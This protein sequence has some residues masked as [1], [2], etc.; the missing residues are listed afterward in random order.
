MT[1]SRS[2]AYI[3]GNPRF[4]LT[5]DS[6]P[7]LQKGQMTMVYKALAPYPDVRSLEELSKRCSAQKYE[8]SYKRAI[9]PGN[10]W[11]FLRMSILYHL[12]RMRE[13]GIIRE[14]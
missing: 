13:R 2:R 5:G 1:I 11:L 8:E 3:D 4:T 9:A 10:A 6:V 12:R 7:R 14:V